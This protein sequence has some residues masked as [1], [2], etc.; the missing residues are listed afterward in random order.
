MTTDHGK[1][2]IINKMTAAR[3]L[4]ELATVWSSIA[5]R[6]QH[7]PQIKQLKEILKAKMERT[8]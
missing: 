3:D 1:K 8:K 4:S 5:F 7:D 2:Y 6:Y